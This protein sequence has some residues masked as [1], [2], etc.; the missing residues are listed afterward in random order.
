M[1]R[2]RLDRPLVRD[3]AEAVPLAIQ[4]GT[5]AIASLSEADLVGASVD[6]RIEMLRQLASATWT[7][8]SEEDAILRVVETTPASQSVA[9]N[10]RLKR[11]HVG[12]RTLRSE[13]DHVV[14]LSNNLK[15][16]SALTTLYLKTLKPSR[17][18]EAV[19]TAPML[20][21]HDVMGFFETTAVF[22]ASPTSDGKIRVEYP[23]V[24]LLS[25][26]DFA[27]ETRDLYDLLVHGRVFDPEDIVR[28]HDYDIDRIVTLTAQDLLA[29]QHTAV[30]NLGTHLAT[31]ASFAVPVSAAESAAGKLLAIT[32]ERVLPAAFLVVDE[33]RHNIVQWFPTWGNHLLK[34][35][36]LAETT[37]NI[38]GFYQFAKHG[39]RVVAEWNRLRSMRRAIKAPSPDAERAA[40][41]IERRWEDVTKTMEELR[42]R[43]GPVTD[44]QH[45]ERVPSAPA[46]E[47]RAPSTAPKTRQI[48]VDTTAH[49]DAT[50]TKY[51]SG[52]V[53]TVEQAPSG[54]KPPESMRAYPVSEYGISKRVRKNVEIERHEILQHAWLE[55]HGLVK[56]RG[57]GRSR[58]TTVLELPHD[59][60]TEISRLQVEAHLH[61]REFL[62][63]LGASEVIDKN[64]AILRKVGVD[65][66]T[67]QR[68]LE[69]VTEML[70]GIG[71]KAPL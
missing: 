10:E 55:I 27:D 8:S 21:W 5:N 39:T 65:D 12:S 58:Y 7:G 1:A 6:Q 52:N 43:G 47:K 33:N 37:V 22:F 28:V 17:G 45:G 50:E 59:V 53:V 35:I 14:D 18:I 69:D 54:K 19:S 48:Q 63:T 61:D 30:R 67:R 26:N 16:H 38:Y 4:A 41:E 42:R 40:V 31:V 49:T 13:L 2:D 51:K 70:A 9:L 71:N 46:P 60:H 66:A 11:E 29:Y 15:L 24:G 62:K 68:I 64:L 32:L 56:T 23:N 25:P 34:F 3:R 44:V 20:P 57:I 36:D